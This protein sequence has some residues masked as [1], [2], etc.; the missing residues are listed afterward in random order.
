VGARDCGTTRVR[1]NRSPLATSGSIEQ[2]TMSDVRSTPALWQASLDDALR[3]GGDMTRA[4]IGAM[5]LRGDRKHVVVDVKVH[6][7][8]PGFCPGIPGW[9]TDGAPRGKDLNPLGRGAPN[10]FA[11]EF[12]EEP[13]FDLQEQRKPHRFHFLV[14]GTASLTEFVDQ[15]LEIAVPNEPTTDLYAHISRAV[16]RLEPRTRSVQSCQV[17][18]FDWWDLHRATFSIGHE[19]R[20]MIRV[21]ETDWWEPQ[22]DLR[23]VMR[24][25]QQVY[26]RTESF[27][28]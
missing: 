24:Q 6:M 27:G 1:F 26:V 23:N 4:A 11:Q 9:H 12:K 22:R 5:A 18:E 8:M 7:L 20:Y 28:W 15:P 16:G 3:Y 17:T 25:Q 19:W 21:T 14:T 10:L 13:R 2:P